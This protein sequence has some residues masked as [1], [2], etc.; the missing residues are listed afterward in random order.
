MDAKMKK[1]KLSGESPALPV[2]VEEPGPTGADE[3][4]SSAEAND[5]A[6][7]A[8]S[9]HEIRDLQAQAAKA[10]EH[11]DN[12]L[13]ATADFEN[14][15]KRV[16]RERQEASKYAHESILKKL[17]PV[18][19]NF[20]MALA[21]AGSAPGGATPTALQAGISM[22]SQQFKSALTEA[23]LEEIDAAN[24]PF[25]PHWHEAVSQQETSEV[26]EGHVLQQL[27]KGYKLRDRLLRPATV[28]VAKKPAG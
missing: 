16:A 12:L 9:A 15:K 10:K 24:Q 14:F 4:A 19:D 8:L 20:D 21:A 25:D 23:G 3:T 27:R 11:W 6:P 22:I 7:A 17:I 13:R 1:T 2:A 28:I 5:T 26:P 18:L